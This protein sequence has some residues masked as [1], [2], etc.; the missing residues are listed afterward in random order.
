MDGDG[1]GNTERVDG[2]VGAFLLFVNEANEDFKCFW[3][4]LMWP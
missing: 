3:A 1:T 2:M 4:V